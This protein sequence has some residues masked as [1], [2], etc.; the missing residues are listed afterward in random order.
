MFIKSVAGLSGGDVTE[1]L[2]VISEHDIEPGQFTDVMDDMEPGANTML[3]DMGDIGL[4]VC[5]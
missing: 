2:S 1:D 5:Y 4:E 3:G